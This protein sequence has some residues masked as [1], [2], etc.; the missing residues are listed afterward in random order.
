MKQKRCSAGFG[1][2]LPPDGEHVTIYFLQQGS[3]AE[4]ARLFFHH[5]SGKRWTNI[6]G[7]LLSNWKRLAWIWIFYA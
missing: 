2:H 6:H 1:R 7:H 3:T 4:N 5:Y